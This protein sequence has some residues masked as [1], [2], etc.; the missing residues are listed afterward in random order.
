MI[1]WIEWQFWSWKSS[2]ATHVAREVARF[3]VKSIAKW[4]SE[5]WNIILSNI[6]MN[7][8]TIPN[9]FYFE[10]DKFLE[11]LR[12]ANAINDLERKLYW[13]KKRGN[14]LTRRK[15]EKFSRI[16]IFFDEVW[17][18]MNNRA[19]KNFNTVISEYINQN[20]K[21]FQEIYLITAD[22]QQS[23]K[24]LRR[25]VEW[26][27][28]VTPFVNLPILKN[29]WIVRRM[30]KDEEWKP[31]LENYV[32]KDQNWDYILKQKPIDERVD[33]FWKPWIWEYYDD[34]HK[35]IRDPEKYI[36]L[37]FKLLNKII[38]RK[39]ELRDVLSHD[40]FINLNQKLITEKI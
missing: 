26:W 31:A 14:T 39:K 4:L 11:I 13:Y 12:T 33:W 28:Y 7:E 40:D 8:I 27:Y 29:I 22:W 3:T 16:Y 6:K 1:H 23:D 18:I 15:R 25:F 2:L 35:N 10:D 19:Y 30:Q 9:Y 37:D 38:S 36:N 20:R 34:L 17:A 24:S 32:W 5:S 21:N